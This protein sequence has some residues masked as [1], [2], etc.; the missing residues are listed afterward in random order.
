MKFGRILFCLKS[1]HSFFFSTDE[2]NGEQNISTIFSVQKHTVRGLHSS[3]EESEDL[4]CTPGSPVSLPQLPTLC[5]SRHKQAK[6]VEGGRSI[7]SPYS[8]NQ[9]KDIEVNRKSRRK[10]GT[11]KSSRLRITSSSSSEDDMEV[12][13]GKTAECKVLHSKAEVNKEG[14]MSVKLDNKKDDSFLNLEELSW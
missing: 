1:Y 3:G 5:R 11:S 9:V 14:G 8:K 10:N 7:E 6:E 12:A 2:N 13:A 4:F